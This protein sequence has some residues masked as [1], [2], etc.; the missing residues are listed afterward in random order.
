L[1]SGVY[2]L[3][4][5][6]A[7]LEL[8]ETGKAI[9]SGLRRPGHPTL[10]ALAYPIWDML[11][12]AGAVGFVMWTV[13]AVPRLG[14]WK[15]WFLDLPVWVTPTFSLLALSRVYEIV[16]SRAR[17]RDV[18]LLVLMLQLGLLL[19]LGIA[20]LID[21]LALQ[22]WFFR[23]L[24]LG[25][26]SHPAMIS[27][28]VIYRVIEEL[29]IWWRIQTEQRQDDNRIL[30]YGAGGR[31]QLFLRERSFSNSSSF[32][33]RA[34]LGLIDDDLTL[35]GRWVYGYM[36]LGGSKDLP[37]IIA[38][39]HITG[40]IITAMLSSESQAVVEE[41]ARQP[42]IQLSEWR[43]EEL[44]LSIPVVRSQPLETPLAVR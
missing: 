44:Q 20:L 24:L 5:H 13:E 21:P 18:F 40:I 8:R 12:M 43:F 42:G 11:W 19:S 1:L 2:V 10:K 14:F 38:R 3:M 34:I 33:A 25:A 31:C 17:G 7:V 41:L 29:V 4:R 9:L 37:K 35:H 15:A 32:D 36:V 28:R 16:W 39:D 22:T 27:V 26:L 23:T 30:L 6:L